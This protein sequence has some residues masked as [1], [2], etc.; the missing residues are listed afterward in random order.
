MDADKDGRLTIEPAN[1]TPL[2]PGPRIP[3]K[4]S[5]NC[6]PVFLAP[7]PGFF[8]VGAEIRS[9]RNGEQTPLSLSDSGENGEICEIWD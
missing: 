6:I 1:R 5:G 4:G 2:L 7:P 9:R 3:L 8:G